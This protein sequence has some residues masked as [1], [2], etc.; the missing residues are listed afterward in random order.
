MKERLAHAYNE[1]TLFLAHT[2]S[3]SMFAY[4]ILKLPISVA[5]AGSTDLCNRAYIKMQRY[6][7][8][9]TS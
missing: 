4:V 3:L 9:F 6:F 5:A 7:L 8:D 2:I 1:P